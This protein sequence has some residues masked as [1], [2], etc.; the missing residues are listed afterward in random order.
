M[1]LQNFDAM[2]DGTIGQTK[3]ARRAGKTLMA[4]HRLECG[5]SMKRGEIV[6]HR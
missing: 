1:L 6:R 3:L 2:A 4:G 5:K